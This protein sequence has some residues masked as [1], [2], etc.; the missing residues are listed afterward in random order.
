MLWKDN[1]DIEALPGHQKL[2]LQEMGIC[3]DY[4]FLKLSTYGG[5]IWIASLMCQ[6]LRFIGGVISWS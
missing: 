5:I 1:S 6:P 2:Y 3:A 4:I